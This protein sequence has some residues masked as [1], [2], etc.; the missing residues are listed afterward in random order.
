[1]VIYEFSKDQIQAL[2]MRTAVMSAFMYMKNVHEQYAGCRILKNVSRVNPPSN[3]Y[4]A[5]IV[6]RPALAFAWAF[7][8][9]ADPDLRRCRLSKQGV[10][11]SLETRP[12]AMAVDEGDIIYGPALFLAHDPDDPR[13]YLDTMY[14]PILGC[15]VPLASNTQMQS[16][17]Y[18]QMLVTDNACSSLYGF[19]NVNLNDFNISFWD[20]CRFVMIVIDTVKMWSDSSNYTTHSIKDLPLSSAFTYG[21][22]WTGYG[23]SYLP[24]IGNPTALTPN[25]N[26]TPP[27]PVAVSSSSLLPYAGPD[28]GLIMGEAASGSYSL[29]FPAGGP[30]CIVPIPGKANMKKAVRIDPTG[31]RSS[32]P[33]GYVEGCFVPI[34]HPLASTVGLY[35]TSPDSDA[36]ALLSPQEVLTLHRLGVPWNTILSSFLGNLGTYLTPT[37]ISTDPDKPASYMF[38]YP[39]F[40]VG[41]PS[42]YIMRM[43]PYYMAG[44][45]TG[46]E[47][48]RITM[49]PLT[50][51]P[52]TESWQLVMK[53]WTAL[54]HLQQIAF[55]DSVLE[56]GLITASVATLTAFSKDFRLRS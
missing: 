14:S 28:S 17:L 55:N 48:S 42:N 19:N 53:R 30:G 20:Y 5:C 39:Q 26:I 50:I 54:P 46:A 34:F 11:D 44:S 47:G 6:K 32:V 1:M 49:R 3:A 2:E 25:P 24:L 22:L 10:L 13:S 8:G 29:N 18:R 27:G 4:F 23:A 41:L 43:L 21:G 37:F 40:T 7:Y 36:L 52:L 56:A 9:S 38:G 35:R 12:W 45:M 31:T 15:P 33:S 51:R 16:P